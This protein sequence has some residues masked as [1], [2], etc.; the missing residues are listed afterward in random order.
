MRKS[1][2]LFSYLII[3][4]IL[5]TQ[6]FQSNSQQSYVNNNQLNCNNNFNNTNGFQCNGNRSS[7]TSYVTF[8][9]QPPYATPPNIAFLLNSSTSDIGQ[10]N[11]ISEVDPI[12]AN[13]LVIVPVS[14]SCTRTSNSNSRYYQHNAQYRLQNP[15]EAYFT[16]ANNTYQGLTTCQAMINQNTYNITDLV[17]GDQLLVPIMCACPTTEQ[18]TQYRSQYLLSYLVT[19]GD[20][21]SQIADMFGATTQSILDANEL[22]TDDVIFPFT[23]ILIPLTSEPTHINLPSSPP[24][25]EPQSAPVTPDTGPRSSSNNGMIIG[26]VVGVGIFM[27]ILV[28]FLV[29]F[30]VRRSSKK[31]ISTFMNNEKGDKVSE[32]PFYT[33]TTVSYTTSQMSTKSSSADFGGLK[34]AIGSL[35]A[36]KFKEIEK[37]TGRFSEGNR[38]KGSVFRGE[39]KGDEAAIKIVKGNIPN[40]EINILKHINHSNIVRLSGYCVNEGN[41]YLVFEYAE[42]DHL[43]TGFLA[44]ISTNLKRT[45]T[46]LERTIR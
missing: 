4:T 20:S 30:L 15:G 35:T 22:K 17:P 23:P 34:L 16:V 33:P 36:Y 42:K 45:M 31:P 8:R 7:C 18:Q 3:L 2:L 25:P 6:I 12:P 38:I 13:R 19:W 43:M 10:L 46:N 1:P 11:N 44:K 29:W 39:L 21:I 28:S 41:T 5:Q 40:D 32:S 37:A 26:V 24:V 9:S 27:I 14:C